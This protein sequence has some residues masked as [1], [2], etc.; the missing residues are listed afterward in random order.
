MAMATTTPINYDGKCD[1]DESDDDEDDKT[2]NDT[3]DYDG[4]KPS[5]R[6][7]PDDDEDGARRLL[8]FQQR[9]IS[10]MCAIGISRKMGNCC[11]ILDAIP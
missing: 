3:D 7:T 6:R 11:Y 10:T 9:H 2:S 8:F 1:I 5:R 4:T